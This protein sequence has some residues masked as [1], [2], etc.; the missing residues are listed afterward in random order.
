[1]DYSADILFEPNGMAPGQA[2]PE[3]RRLDAAEVAALNEI[4]LKA[5][6]QARPDDQSILPAAAGRFSALGRQDLAVACW[7]R[8]ASFRPLDRAEGLQQADALYGSGHVEA[9]SAILLSILDEEQDS[10]E[11]SLICHAA[12]FMQAAQKPEQALALLECYRTS[13]ADN[14]AFQAQLSDAHLRLGHLKEAVETGR[15]ATEL[16]PDVPHNHFMLAQALIR[17]KNYAEAEKSLAAPCCAAEPY[18]YYLHADIARGRDDFNSAYMWLDRAL[19]I[20]PAFRDALYL[21][22]FLLGVERKWPEAI[23]GYEAALVASPNDEPIMR[24]AL[25]AYIEGKDFDAAMPIASSLVARYPED[26]DIQHAIKIVTEHRLGLAGSISMRDFD[27]DDFSKFGKP[28]SVRKEARRPGIW[29]AIVLQINI[30]M[31]LIV[32]EARTRFGKSSL[33]YLWVIFEPFAHIG[34]MI[35][36][37][38]VIGHGK[39]PPIGESFS[40]FYFTGVVPYHLFSHSLSH[41]T[42]A[43]PENKPMLNLPAVHLSDVLIARAVLELLTETCVAAF[44][45]V[46]IYG[47]GVDITPLNILGVLLGFFLIWVAGVGC[48]M[49]SSVIALYFKGWPKI[50]GALNSLLY[51][52][53]GTFFIARMMP[54]WVRDIL[55]WNPVL[56]AIE[57]IRLNYFPQPYP[58]WLDLGYLAV[59][60]LISLAAGLACTRLFHHE[61]LVSE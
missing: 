47:F 37:V 57:Q 18:T 28:P 7:Q 30:I 20:N 60:A 26:N 43:V 39:G 3:T 6:L 2:L 52:S 59:F 5:Y 31:A 23:K 40:I 14:A 29:P 58:H 50:V 49:I 1:M 17:A 15:R 42:H 61:L 55:A 45:L 34:I 22:A 12:S 44:I 35:M 10:A 9:A 24:S 11:A 48:G 19:A 13:C 46:V 21:K 16:G 41:M 8:L 33:G 4:A 54:I 56:Q 32:R 53:S 38:S 25:V 51:F 36:L 27:P